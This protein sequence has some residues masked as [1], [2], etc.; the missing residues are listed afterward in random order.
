MTH[1][2]ASSPASAEIIAFRSRIHDA[3]SKDCARHQPPT[4]LISVLD[5]LDHGIV[6]NDVDGLA[7]LNR[8]ADLEL[9]EP[10]GPLHVRDGSLSAAE[11]DEAALLR[12]SLSDASLRGKRRVLTLH[13]RA[14]TLNVSIA[15]VQ[16]AGGSDEPVPALVMLPRGSLCSRLAAQWFASAHGLSTAE[17]S[18][19]AELLAGRDPAQIA[20][21]HGVAISTVRTQLSSIKAKTSTRSLRHLLMV[22]AQLPPLV[23]V[24]GRIWS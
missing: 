22:A 20:A 3:T 7:H 23:P 19:F 5:Q 15:P 9:A 10:G 21:S 13:G 12:R 24:A 16:S 18:V 8:L 1:A 6:L 11:P 14:R 2:T 17:T 4:C